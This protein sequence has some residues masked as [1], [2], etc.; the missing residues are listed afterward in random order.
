MKK[1]LVYFLII[2][3]IMSLMSGCSFKRISLEEDIINMQ[4]GGF[5]YTS[6]ARAD[7]K[8]ERAFLKARSNAVDETID[9]M[10]KAAKHAFSLND[11]FSNY[12]DNIR[13][14]MGK[15]NE[16]SSVDASVL[17]DIL[18]R[19][20][21]YRVILESYEE[22]INKYRKMKPDSPAVQSILNTYMIDATCKLIDKQNEYAAWLINNTASVAVILEKENHRQSDRLISTSSSIYVKQIDGNFID[23]IENYEAG[24]FL[25][26]VILSA[27]YYVSSTYLENAEKTINKLKSDESETSATPE[28]IAELKAMYDEAVNS[29]KKPS[30]LKQI[31][32]VKTPFTL[33]RKVSAAEKYSNGFIMVVSMFEFY[34]NLNIYE[35][36]FEAIPPSD[37]EMIDNQLKEKKRRD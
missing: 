27:D 29:I 31:P 17:F 16:A 25:N 2:A 35:M 7:T 5:L 23:A 21:A 13:K 12:E 34:T 14:Y 11:S 18:E 6:L 36:S 1:S 24:A 8:D 26:S 19:I 10:G 3:V 30:V 20:T 22:E 33:T 9:Y 32:E 15:I 28:E 37:K 4:M